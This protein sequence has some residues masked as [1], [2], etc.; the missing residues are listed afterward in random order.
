[1]AAASPPWLADPLSAG[2]VPDPKSPESKASRRKRIS[3][4]LSRAAAAILL[5]PLAAA[6]GRVALLKSVAPAT[7]GAAVPGGVGSGDVRGGGSACGL[8]SW[9][10]PASLTRKGAGALSHGNILD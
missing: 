4:L 10:G 3:W 5:R 6:A 2:A 9:A 7:T 8:F 1:V